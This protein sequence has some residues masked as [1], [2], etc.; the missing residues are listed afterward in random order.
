MTKGYAINARS[1]LSWNGCDMVDD[2]RWCASSGG[3][4][5]VVIYGTLPRDWYLELQVEFFQINN[6]LASGEY[7][8]P[9]PVQREQTNFHQRR[10]SAHHL[11]IGPAHA[12]GPKIRTLT[13]PAS[14]PFKV[15]F[16]PCPTTIILLH[17]LHPFHLLVVLPFHPGRNSPSSSVVRQPVAGL[18]GTQAPSQLLPRTPRLSSVDECRSHHWGFQDLP[19]SPVHFL[20]L[21]PGKTVCRAVVQ[22]MRMRSMIVKLRQMDPPHLPLHDEWVLVQ[23]HFETWKQELEWAIMVDSPWI[24]FL[25]ARSRRGL[26]SSHTSTDKHL[27]I[28]SN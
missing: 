6:L 2:F 16:L 10:S 3:V 20:R 19:L 9:S 28:I 12:K 24:G 23:G 17:P 18:Q 13:H 5:H 25:P 11:I 14:H 15:P 8:T 21:E 26:S 7:R 27:R 22:L 1:F 4:H